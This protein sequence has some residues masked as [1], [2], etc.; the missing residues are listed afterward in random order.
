MTGFG[1][2]YCPLLPW[3]TTIILVMT[4]YLQYYISLKHNCAS[5]KKTWTNAKTRTLYMIISFVYMLFPSFI[6]VYFI[7]L[8][9]VTSNCGPFEAG[10]PPIYVT[11]IITED[12]RV[13]FWLFNSPVWAGITG[14]E[15]SIRLLLLS[16]NFLVFSWFH[17]ALL[18]RLDVTGSAEAT[19]EVPFI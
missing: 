12:R 6:F 8:Y 17:R 14:R 2:F 7:S 13:S 18:L 9:E 15:E 19:Q 4:F 1:Y 5:S 10:R 16:L 11:G 3:M